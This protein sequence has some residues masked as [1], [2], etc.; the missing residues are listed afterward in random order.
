MWI[1]PQTLQ[2]LPARDASATALR[3]SDLEIRYPGIAGSSAVVAVD[4]LS[5]QVEAGEA[6]G[7]LGESG[8]G[9]TSLALGATGLLPK[10]AEVSGDIEVVGRE[11]VEETQ[12]RRLRGDMVGVVFQQPSLALHPMRR[13]GAQIGDVLRSHRSW[14]RSRYKTRVFELLDE[15]ELPRESFGAYPHQLSGGQQQ[16]VVL[17]Q[18]LACEPSLLVAD[19]PTA[20]LDRETE[21][22]VLALI[23]R[24]RKQRAMALLWISHHPDVLL[25]VTDRL[26]VM[27]AGRWMEQ[28]DT[29]K[30]LASPC[31]PY[32]RALLACRPNR[33]AQAKEP[34]GLR[35]LSVIPKALPSSSHGQ[36]CAFAPRCSRRID[37]CEQVLAPSPS[38]CGET[39]CCREQIE[40]D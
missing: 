27:Y 31:H 34:L 14:P 15:L 9:K 21:Q 23:A 18:A 5:L 33:K 17:A 13:I 29:A 35:K 10:T 36:G 37:D 19:E 30:L 12:W 1:P 3:L 40:H 25:E 7:I 28:G 22:Q 26:Y 8:C 20:A 38:H 39:W 2:P 32:T 4:R 11:V 16:R 24:L 6:V